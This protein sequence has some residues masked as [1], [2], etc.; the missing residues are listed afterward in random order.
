[1]VIYPVDSVIYVLN[2]WDQ[3][4]VQCDKVKSEF[5]PWNL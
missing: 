4:S 2:N 5:K 3:Y 1:M